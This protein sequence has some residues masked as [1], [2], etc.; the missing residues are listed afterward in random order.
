MVLRAIVEEMVDQ[1][2]VAEGWDDELFLVEVQATG[3]PGFTK[4]TVLLDG[5]RG[6]DID[7]CAR[8]SRRL[9][10][11]IEETNLVES[12]YVLEVSSP[13]VDTPL[14]LRRQYLRNVGR[15]VKVTLTDGNLR[16]G[17][18]EAVDE[19]GIR[20][21]EAAKGKK[22]P[23]SRFSPGETTPDG[24]ARIAWTAIQRTL[25]VVSF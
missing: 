23:L 12:A 14:Q 10:G 15:N 22:P 7:R 21:V 1:I 6:I 16:S 19:E 25:V 17:R 4:L 13:G 3:N 5:D 18:L 11:R 2:L 8:I 9:G 24:E 20:L